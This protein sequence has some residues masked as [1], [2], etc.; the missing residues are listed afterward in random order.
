MNALNRP[1]FGRA[2]NIGTLY[3]AIHDRFLPVSILDEPL[4]PNALI[5]TP[6][7]KTEITRSRRHLPRPNLGALKLD[8]DTAAS[9]F[10]QLFVPQGCGT[11]LRDYAIY[12][13]PLHGSFYH[14]VTTVSQQLQSGFVCSTLSQHIGSAPLLDYKG[15]YVVTGITW[16]MENMITIDHSLSHNVSLGDAQNAFRRDMD[17]LEAVIKSPAA[18][19]ELELQQNF[20]IYS[21]AHLH[22]GIVAPELEDVSRFIQIVPDHI[23]KESGG[24]GWPISYALLPLSILLSAEPATDASEFFTIPRGS[25]A[26]YEF[27]NMFQSYAQKE[28][29]LVNYHSFLLDH[30]SQVAEDH[31]KAVEEAKE[32]LSMHQYNAIASSRNE[33]LKARSSKSTRRNLENLIR[34]LAR[35]KTSPRKIPAIAGQ[36][37]KKL[38]FVSAAISA[39]AS[40]IGYNG[41]SFHDIIKPGNGPG[42]F[43][44]LFNKTVMKDDKTWSENYSL[45]MKLLAEA[46]RTI[47]VYIVDCEA[48][49]VDLEAARISKYCGGQILIDDLLQYHRL[50]LNPE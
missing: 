35:G 19:D 31:V 32:T 28:N 26:I 36:E 13:K 33:L 43:G 21:S 44:F 9:I 8:G 6:C 15:T 24:K 12:G 16:G 7:P 10:G 50:Q 46:D 23:S 1:A 48:A 42:C 25:G 17:K 37:T 41:L 11:Y 39:G 2:A 47:P 14:R 30:G 20:R 40:Y 38:A 49:G 4:P 45:L 3:D 29:E 18:A 22:E 27:I 5:T 34:R